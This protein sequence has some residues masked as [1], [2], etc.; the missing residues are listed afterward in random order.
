MA[1]PLL[2]ILH[3]AVTASILL[4]TIIATALFSKSFWS[5][6]ITDVKSELYEDE[7]GVA[8]P[9]SQKSYTIKVQNVLATIVTSAGLGIAIADA[10]LRTLEVPHA[11]NGSAFEN[12]WF[13][14]GIWVGFN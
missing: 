5:K 10:V 14:V 3:I 9:E 8:T 6:N 11:L 4:L 2:L 1:L 12:G 13:G 7:D